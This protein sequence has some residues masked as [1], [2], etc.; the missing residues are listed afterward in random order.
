[1][2]IRFQVD[3]DFYDHPKVTGM[4]DAAFA[5]WVRAGSYSAAKL[6]DGFVSDNVL[7]HTLR[8]ERPVADE[9]VERGLWR[10]ARGGWRFHQWENR[11][12]IKERIEADLKNDRER[13]RA[14]RNKGGDATDPMVQNGSEQVSVPN[15]RP[16]SDRTPGGLRP[17]STVIP[18]RSVSVSLS[19]SPSSSVGGG[20]PVGR[21]APA[22]RPPERCPM[23]TDDPDPPNCGKCADQRRSVE[24]WD[25]QNHLDERLTIRSCGLCDGD[26]YRL[27]SGRRI[28]IT[29]Y[30]RCDHQREQVLT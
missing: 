10:R 3:P 8:Y 15:V 4:S 5:L 26:G 7:A 16:D 23:H 2:P 29:P 18:D 22:Q 11:N 9:L 19:V 17:D 28:P 30:V 14:A 25:R 24:A 13:K 21:R 12:L 1:M 20:R 6:T 27:V